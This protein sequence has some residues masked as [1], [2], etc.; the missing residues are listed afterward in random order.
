MSV[1]SEQFEEVIHRCE[2]S[3]THGSVTAIR[4]LSDTDVRSIFEALHHNKPPPT[5]LSFSIVRVGPNGL[6]LSPPSYEFS[7]TS[8]L[9]S[10][11]ILGVT[12]RA[13][14]SQPNR[15]LLC[16]H[17][18]PRRWPVCTIAPHQEKQETIR[19]VYRSTAATSTFAAFDTG[20]RFPRDMPLEFVRTSVSSTHRHPATI[21]LSKRAS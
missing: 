5:H 18:I 12:N 19:R 10:V 21:L 9:L 13:S 8:C 17:Y 3:P 11:L 2:S 20:G 1:T 16:I 6:K 14:Y 4:R 15:I 7:G